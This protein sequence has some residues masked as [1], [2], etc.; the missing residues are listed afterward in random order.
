MKFKQLLFLKKLLVFACLLS[1]YIAP[2]QA[3]NFS[4]GVFQFQ[5][6]LAA[7]GDAQAQYKLAYM[8][9]TG[10]GIKVDL[11]KA[12]E[13]YQKAAAQNHPDAQMRLTYISIKKDGY[14]SAKHS[15]WLKKLQ[16]DAA[17]SGEAMLL[18]GTLYKN[19][20]IFRKNL[21][22][23][24]KL[25]KSAANKNV[26]SAEAE[27]ESVNAILF[28]QQNKQKARDKQK[29]LDSEKR[30]KDQ[31]KQLASQQKTDEER[32]RKQAIQRAERERIAAEKERL[33]LAMEKQKLLEEKQRLQEKRKALLLKQ[34]Q[35]EQA[36]LSTPPETDNEETKPEPKKFDKNICKGKKARFLTICR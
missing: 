1:V 36:A 18:L 25:F 13:W 27:L 21:N 33:A 15:G 31:K 12:M 23:A 34:A 19:G 20:F 8:Y 17:N 26:T 5:Q 29:K 9:E 2:A 30:K 11:D 35:A 16:K 7:K 3:Y 32:K 4:A 22:K 28:T 24:A 10:Q 6:K 14:R